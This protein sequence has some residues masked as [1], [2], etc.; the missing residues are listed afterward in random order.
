MPVAADEAASFSFFFAGD[1]GYSKD[2]A[3]IGKRFGSFDFALLPIGAYEPRW[4]MKAQHVNPGEAVKIHQE[5]KANRSIA[6]HWGTFELA[7]EALDEAPKALPEELQKANV[8]P[9]RFVVPR[10]GE[11]IRF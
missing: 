5:I 9:A 10:H 7:D 11:T 4:F 6:I 8:G 3:D 2:F 1:A